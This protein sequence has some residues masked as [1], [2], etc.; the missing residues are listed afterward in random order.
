MLVDGTDRRRKNVD[1]GRVAIIFAS[2][3]YRSFKV[4]VRT[5]VR[6]RVRGRVR[7]R[8]SASRVRAI[9]A[10][11]SRV[12]ASRVKSFHPNPNPSK[13]KCSPYP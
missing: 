1:S 11:A 10:R 5:R 8:V 3:S 13:E 7:V 4:R 9:R 2:D 6:A 12:R